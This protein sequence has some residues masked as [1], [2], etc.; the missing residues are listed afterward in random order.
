MSCSFSVSATALVISKKLKGLVSCNCH[1]RDKVKNTKDTVISHGK[2][3]KTQRT[4]GK[5]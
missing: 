2:E 3:R 5:E 1:P 4:A